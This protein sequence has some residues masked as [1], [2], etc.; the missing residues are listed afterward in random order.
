MTLTHRFRLVGLQLRYEQLA[1]WRNGRRAFLTL[2]FP[3]MF[4]LVVGTLTRGSQID[5]LGISFETFYV[6]GI[7]AYGVVTQAFSN[8]ATSMVSARDT[9]VIKRVQGA[10]VPWSVWVAGRIAS[11]VVVTCAMCG[12]TLGLGWALLGVE[13]RP[14]TL[15]GL[16]L[17]IVMGTLCFTTLGIGLVPA[18][19]SVDTAGPMQA[20][21]VTP[22]SLVS[23]VFFP[24]EAAPAWIDA[25]AGA[26]PLK[27][28]ADA[29]HVAFDPATAA[30]GIAG[31]D[32]LVLAIW[33]LGGVWLMMR[34]LKA[35]TRRR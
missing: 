18:L 24:L 7:L 19:P 34:F 33:S 17:A 11:T 27:P 9:G 31:S 6:P 28:L 29:M 30:P 20:F 25:L 5:S 13:V 4:L 26:L 15:P 12:L 23:N 3:L 1:F 10:P 8:L 32:L 35:A 21:L 2:G 22:V 16:T 14:E